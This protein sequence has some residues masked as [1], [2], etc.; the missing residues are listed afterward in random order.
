MSLPNQSRSPL[1]STEGGNRSD[2]AEPP[3]SETPTLP[4][5][6]EATSSRWPQVTGYEILA[7]LGRGG[8]G[9]VFNAD[10]RGGKIINLFRR[11]LV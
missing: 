5:V 1:P 4:P 10:F 11:L 3:G 6:T 7:E 9:V 2:L 8:M